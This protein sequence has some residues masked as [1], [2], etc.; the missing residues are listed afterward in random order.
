VVL[1]KDLKVV[2]ANASFYKTFRVTR[3]VT[4]G[5]QIYAIGNGQWNIDKLR[6]LLEKIIPQN[7]EVDDYEVAHDFEHI[8]QKVMLLNARQIIR[9]DNRQK[10][11]LLAIEDI[12]FH[13]QLEQQTRDPEAQINNILEN[14]VGSSMRISG[15]TA[16]QEAPKE[17]GSAD[18]PKEPDN[19]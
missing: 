1:D 3:E 12:T 7:K 4:E 18:L 9:Q 17:R 16:P 14:L 5:R 2:L 8:G 19:T 13:K 11:L 10:V 15:G 6:V